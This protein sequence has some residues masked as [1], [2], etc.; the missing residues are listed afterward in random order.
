VSF[1]VTSRAA[2]ASF[3]K[4]LQASRV[5]GREREALAYFEAAVIL[6]VYHR[7]GEA[8]P[9]YRSYYGLALGLVADEPQRGLRLC[10]DAADEMP[11][12]ADLFLN[13]G[14]LE[15]KAGDRQEALRALN[16]GSHLADDKEIFRKFLEHLKKPRR[17]VIPFFPPS[18]PLN[19]L[20][21]RITRLGSR[22]AAEPAT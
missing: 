12:E 1:H 7:K 21:G 4:G 16:R 13:L 18:H 20:A 17:K 5:R 3:R 15:L 8:L 11:Y 9:R 22:D 2:E 6:D 14:R 10:R 19:V